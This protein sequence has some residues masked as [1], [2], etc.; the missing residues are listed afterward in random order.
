MFWHFGITCWGFESSSIIRFQKQVMWMLS[1]GKCNPHTE[2]FF[3]EMKLLNVRYIQFMS[4]AWNFDKN[5][6]LVRFP[7]VSVLCFA[8]TT[9]FIET[10][11][12]RSLHLFPTRTN[13]ARLV[14]RHYTSK[15]LRK[16]PDDDMSSPYSQCW[17]F[18]FSHKI[19]SNR[20]V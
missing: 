7:N 9:K 19:V 17:Y 20:F 15:L 2:P 1:L 11:I 12:H 8:T 14:M 3:K 13:G 10:R 18:C 5:S 16:F 6:P 4:N